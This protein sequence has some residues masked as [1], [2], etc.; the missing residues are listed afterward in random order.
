M[1]PGYLHVPQ[2]EEESDSDIDIFFTPNTSPR[3]SMASTG[4]A[5]RKLSRRSLNSTDSSRPNPKP[6]SSTS[7]A[8]VAVP[9][10]RT[11]STS[12]TNYGS[13]Q[14]RLSSV[15]IS[16]TMLDAHSLYLDET[17]DRSEGEREVT[18]NKAESGRWRNQ[19]YAEEEWAK[20]VR[21]LVPPPS[22]SSN[23]SK[24]KTSSTTKTTPVTGGRSTTPQTNKK[25]TSYAGLGVSSGVE[26]QNSS[27]TTPPNVRSKEREKPRP[28]A[29]PTTTSTNRSPA[30]QPAQQSQP[31]KPRRPQPHTFSAF[32]S[33]ATPDIPAGGSS[34][35][36]TTTAS[37][38]KPHALSSTANGNN[39][40][41][42]S[43][44]PPQGS[45]TTAIVTSTGSKATNTPT[46]T[47]TSTTSRTSQGHTHSSSTTS[48][49][50]QKNDR[51]KPPPS[52]TKKPHPS[53][54]T[55]N[56][57][58]TST[59]RAHRSSNPPSSSSPTSF[60]SPPK[61]TTTPPART[62]NPKPK[63][64]SNMNGGMSALMEEDEEG[65]LTPRMAHREIDYG[66]S[67]SSK[68]D[69][70]SR[71]STPGGAK[72]TTTDQSRSLRHTSKP[73][74]LRRRRSRSLDSLTN[75]L[76]SSSNSAS[77]FRKPPQTLQSEVTALLSTF[78]HPG[79]LPSKGTQG[80]TSLVLPRAP[81]P[82]G[83][84]VAA[85]SLSPNGKID[86]TRTGIA[87][88]TMATV[89]VVRG[90]GASRGIFGLFG[91]KRTLS[92][93]GGT[94]PLPLPLG[95]AGVRRASADAGIPSAAENPPAM[96][97][98]RTTPMGFTSYRPP[99]NH[100]PSGSVLVQ[101]WAV[102][103][104]GIDGRLVG[105]RFGAEMGRGA[106]YHAQRGGR[107][108]QDDAGQETERDDEDTEHEDE[109]ERREN[110]ETDAEELSTAQTNPSTKKGPLAALGR[111]LSQRLSR[112]T[113][114]NR[115]EK[116]MN[117]NTNGNANANVNHTDSSAKSKPIS[118][119]KRSLSFS[120]KRSNTATSHASS[121]K[122]ASS[123]AIQIPNPPAKRAPKT[124]TRADVGYIPGRS[125]VGRVLECGWDVRDEIVRKG[126]WVVGLL[127][128]R[129]VTLSLSSDSEEEKLT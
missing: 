40:R 41:Q 84:A 32:A 96:I 53:S 55:P 87:Q 21:W 101:V 90:L 88:T 61:S 30:P 85:T 38:S 39:G 6:T 29:S 128:V 50:P 7:P 79:E 77:T 82:M 122:S 104:D 74:A 11:P 86:L 75:S 92:S 129:K 48:I 13:T 80:Y 47:S 72:S 127:D 17:P 43:S 60:T 1:Q 66:S 117:G 123:S 42:P 10:T 67:G 45:S 116:R 70:H 3:A 125:F 23:P 107:R 4:T 97:K 62:R 22:S 78:S 31:P 99:P 83:A 16:S 103:L 51:P 76:H 95:G 36:T 115:K 56:S 37:I 5:R 110:E 54:Y 106:A 33:I 98:R 121:A 34:S 112:A 69:A 28:I 119:P 118:P 2:R 124:R 126:E 35:N 113:S 120:L 8:I 89:E 105:V 44:K 19:K 73:D 64:I 100:V 68:H 24:S 91:R 46:S 65:P 27:S 71:E 49:P 57:N 114:T 63:P 59:T 9:S 25:T 109:E 94:G 93:S 12:S 18:Y 52:D 20:D 14:D 26:I 111:S 81:A 15:S 102:A 58:S 108:Q